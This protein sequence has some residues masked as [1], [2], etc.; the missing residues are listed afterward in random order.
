MAENI[1]GVIYE[2]ILSKGYGLMPQMITRDK[3]LSIEAK[4][5]Y[6]YLAAFA[7]NNHEA[8]PGVELI[9]A[10]LNISKKRYLNHRKALIEKGYIEIVRKRLESGFSKNYYLLK[11]NIP[12]GVDSLPYETL[13][14][15]NVGLRGVTVQNDPTNINSLKSISI[16]NNNNKNYQ[17]NNQPTIDN[18]VSMTSR[19]GTETDLDTDL[20][21]DKE[22]ETDNRQETEVGQSVVYQFYESNIGPLSPF[23]G[24]QIG[25][26][27]DEYGSSLVLEAL[28][29]SVIANA[30]N[31]IKYAQGILRNWHSENIK[32]L[33]DLEMK[34]KRGEQNGKNNRG[35]HGSSQGENDR[36]IIFGDYCS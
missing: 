33:H 20:D 25:Y 35:S 12:Y 8:F 10:E 26:E 32:S 1:N 23:V 19:D 13:P 9:C 18:N 6:G 30:R 36:P 17:S 21:I 24:E 29:E 22:K 5:I 34:R 28:K 27:I 2:G 4:A 31:K 14:Y 3:D 11:Q 15:Q 16:N 7:G